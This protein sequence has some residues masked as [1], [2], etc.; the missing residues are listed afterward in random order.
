MASLRVVG[1][2]ATDLVARLDHAAR[3]ETLEDIIH[4]GIAQVP[5]FDVI[6]VIVQDEYNRDAIVRGS[7]VYLVFD[8]T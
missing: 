8:T 4:W 7:D 1:T 3:L 2:P 5:A 6:D